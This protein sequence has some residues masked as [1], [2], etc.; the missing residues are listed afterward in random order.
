[1]KRMIVLSI[2]WL[3]SSVG[4]SVQASAFSALSAE[5]YGEQHY[6]VDTDITTLPDGGE[7][8]D[9]DSNVVLRADY[10]RYKEGAFI[11]ASGVEVEGDFGT[12]RSPEI[13]L[14]AELETLEA[15]GPVELTGSGWVL[16]ANALLIY[17]SPNVAI[18]EGDVLGETPPLE[19]AALIVDMDQEGAL[20]IG[21]YLYQDGPIALRSSTEGDLLQV[22]WQ[23]VDSDEAVDET[24]FSAS[25]EIDEA[26]HERLIGYL[27]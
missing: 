4:S 12:L 23:Q 16:S 2:L 17:L 8:T 5:P 13:Y 6:D 7:V 20:L 27:R 24:D 10:V 25:T 14:D 26:L 3:L 21:P 11:E 19:G 15:N 18:L 1:M 22:T 9:R